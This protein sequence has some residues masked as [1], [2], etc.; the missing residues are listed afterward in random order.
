ML[1]EQPIVDEDDIDEYTYAYLGYDMFG[2]YCESDN[3]Y[4]VIKSTPAQV[5]CLTCLSSVKTCK[6]VRSFYG[7][8]GD[9][10]EEFRTESI[11]FCGAL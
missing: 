9:K 3:S 8:G 11:S 6:R 7:H 1:P 2:V 10:C 4:S 5:K